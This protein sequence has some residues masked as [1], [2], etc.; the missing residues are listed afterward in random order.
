MFLVLMQLLPGKRT[1][2][3]DTSLD[4]GFLVVPNTVVFKHVSKHQ[5]LHMQ[6]KKQT[7][8][9]VSISCGSLPF[10]RR[11]GS[12]RLCPLLTAMHSMMTSEC[13]RQWPSCL[14]EEGTNISKQFNYSEN[15]SLLA[16]VK[17]AY[18]YFSALI[19]HLK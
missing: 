8:S 9:G 3:L 2:V 16:Q 1:N 19:F 10:Q 11:A 7:E 18:G 12:G 4:M 13:A 14:I 6:I 5:I 17:R 15:A